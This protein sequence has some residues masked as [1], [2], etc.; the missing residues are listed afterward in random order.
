[1]EAEFARAQ[2][3][4]HALSLLMV[5]LDFFKRVN[6]SYGHDVGD[7]VL[8]A[9]AECAVRTLRDSDLFARLGGEEFCACL[10]V[11]SARCGSGTAR[12]LA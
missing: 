10:P 11:T 12:R 6:D 5:D 4:G 7:M 2:R 8:K 1:M 3:Y 9:M